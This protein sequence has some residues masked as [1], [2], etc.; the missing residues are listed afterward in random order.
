MV[1]GFAIVLLFLFAHF[2]EPKSHLQ[3][4]QLSCGGKV[5]VFANMDACTNDS[6]YRAG[7]GCGPVKNPW[8]ATYQWGLIPLL[9]GFL[10]AATLIGSVTRR[11]V[12]LNGAVVIGLVAQSSMH[13]FFNDR[14]S[15]VDLYF[16]LLF[17]PL[18][19]AA[20]CILVTAWFAALRFSVRWIRSRT[21][22]T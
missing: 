18:I 8:Y 9:A 15:S 21:S 16:N 6:G 22:A 5:T 4:A 2:V 1:A 7:C 13:A 14:Y 20:L 10:G 12:F 17:F 19:A 3:Q 11:L